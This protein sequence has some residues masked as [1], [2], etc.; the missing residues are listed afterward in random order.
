MASRGKRKGPYPYWQ[1]ISSGKRKKTKDNVAN[2]LGESFQ[3]DSNTE[4]SKIVQWKEPRF[5]DGVQLS[6]QQQYVLDLIRQGKN[7]FYTGNAGTGKTTLLKEIRKCA[8]EGTFVTAL[9]RVIVI[10]IKQ[11]SHWRHK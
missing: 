2:S 6:A 10:L 9:V 7:V 4:S 5:E 11:C 8:P 3:E 1:W